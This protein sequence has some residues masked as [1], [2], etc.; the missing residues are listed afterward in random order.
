M[1]RPFASLSL[2][3]D[4]QWSYMKTH[5]D[6]G[7]ETF[8]SYLDLVV[9]R[10]LEFLDDHELRITFFVVGQDA[11]IDTNAVALQTIVA[12][13]HEIGNHSFRHEPWLHRYSDAEVNEELRSA[14]EAI[15]A[16]T[17]RQPIGFRGPGYSLSPAV[18]QTLIDLGYQFDATTLP[19]FI[20]PLARAYYLRTSDLPREALEQR[21]ALFGKFTEGLR[22]LKPYRWELNGEYLIE[23]PVTTMPLLRVPIHFSYLLY[24]AAVSP[25]VARVYFA[26]ALRLCRWT[27]VG[28]SL[29]FHPLDFLDSNDIPELA[30]FPGMDVEHTQK[31][32]LLSAYVGTLGQHFEIGGMG[33][34]ASLAA[35]GRLRT[36]QPRA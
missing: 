20:G 33:R 4:N 12:A 2:D 24:L 3:L 22:P 36:V 5:G 25:A 30:F 18:L 31:L 6:P 32:E 29:L 26:W 7:W 27:G 15:A 16:V 21:E 23:I 1:T 17:G 14:H 11:A 13:G 8:P 28:P 9:P 10:V 35:T 34:H 19:T